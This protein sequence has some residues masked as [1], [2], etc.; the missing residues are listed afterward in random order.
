MALTLLFGAVTTAIDAY[1]RKQEEAR[2]SAVDAANSYEEQANA[3]DELKQKYIDITDS[4]GTETEKTEELN[5]W[6]QTLIETY[7]FEKEALENINLEREKGL[8]L[9]EEE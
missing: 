9:L 4:E 1:E 2:Q 6:K 8:G 3:L 7:G 5:E